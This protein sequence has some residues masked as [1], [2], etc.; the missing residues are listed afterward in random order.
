M[1]PAYDGSIPDTISNEQYVN[2]SLKTAN[3]VSKPKIGIKVCNLY[4]IKKKNK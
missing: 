1:W 3:K 4:N 2:N